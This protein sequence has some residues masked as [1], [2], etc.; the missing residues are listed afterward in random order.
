MK[1]Q[2]KHPMMQNFEIE[3][4][5][6]TQIIGTNQQ[7]KYTIFQLF[8]WYFGGR[9]YLEEDLTLLSM[10]DPC[11]KVDG[12][13]IN[14]RSFKLFTIKTLDSLSE[15]VS[16]KKGTLAFDYL[17]GVFRSI[18]LMEHLEDINNQLLRMSSIINLRMESP[19][20]NVKYSV[21]PIEFTKDSIIQKQLR[22]S[23]QIL[24]TNVSFDILDSRDKCDIFLNMLS[25]YCEK[26]TEK[27]MI[28]ISS[29][30]AE[31]SYS[32]FRYLCEQLDELTKTYPNLWVISF[33]SGN[34]NGYITQDTIEGV[35]IAGDQVATLY[36]LSFFHSR[37]ANRYPSTDFPNELEFLAT[38]QRIAYCLLT[39]DISIYSLSIDDETIIKIVNELYGFRTIN[40]LKKSGNELNVRF[41]GKY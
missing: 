40:C 22:P 25:A 16:Y 21:E 30:S 26:S 1:W 12:E 14:R 8:E 28:M 2:L 31:L 24:N 32:D 19:S 13:V 36:E 17:Q 29:V 18:D 4:K 7:L 39:E 15:H 5:Q 9:K 10:D 27:I 33:V 11:I 38:L 6:F 20:F 23:Y 41:I 37:V 34:G 3:I 35:T